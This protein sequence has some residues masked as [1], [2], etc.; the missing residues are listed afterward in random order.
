VND[1]SATAYPAA[2]SQAGGELFLVVGLTG[3][4]IKMFFDFMWDTW[5][6]DLLVQVI[7]LCPALCCT[8]WPSYLIIGVRQTVPPVLSEKKKNLTD[9]DDPLAFYRIWANQTNL[10]SPE[11]MCMQVSLN[12]SKPRFYKEN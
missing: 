9:E 12:Q 8:L 7:S 1:H 3:P 2:L 10:V 5:I 6:P 4:S 11:W